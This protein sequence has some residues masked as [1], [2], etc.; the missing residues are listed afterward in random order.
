M[1]FSLTNA[2]GSLANEI[3]GRFK[4]DPKITEQILLALP[5][6]KEDVNKKNLEKNLELTPYSNHCK[7]IIEKSILSL[8]AR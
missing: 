4:I 3:I 7:Q 2:K 8:K 5:I 6:F 1:F